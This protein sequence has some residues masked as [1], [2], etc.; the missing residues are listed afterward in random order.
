VAAPLPHAIADNCQ[1]WNPTVFPAV[2]ALLR[3]LTLADVS[4]ES[5][6]SLRTVISAGSPLTPEVARS[7]FEKYGRRV[8]SFYGS[9]ET[10]GITYDRTGDATLEGRSV[11]TPL[12]GVH[13]H[14]QRGKRFIVE[15]GA[16][17]TIGN[18]RV[19][20]QD[21]DTDN[22]SNGR[23]LTADRGELNSLGELHLL[24][25]AGRMMKIAGR[26][27]DLTELEATVRKISGVRD[28][29]FTAHPHRPDELAAVVAS[30]LDLEGVRGLLRREL[31]PWKVPKKLIALGQFPLT[32]RGKTDTAALRRIISK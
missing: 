15:S 1:R 2:P 7:F 21:P 14:F 23:H 16:V 18:R 27:I 11:G 6:A 19:R 3:L 13:L 8:H 31:A 26:R 30:D 5:F 12:Q 17:F 24:G 22:W 10:G 20:H 9:S 32:G 28:A 25:R 29:F 4:P